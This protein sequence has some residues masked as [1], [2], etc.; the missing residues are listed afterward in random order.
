MTDAAELVRARV[1]DSVQ[2]KS[3]LLEGD[4]PERL[5]EAAQ[6]VTDALTAGGKVLFFGNGGSAADAMH[7]A[8]ELVG[9]FA[10]DR[11][12]LPALALADSASAVT[13]IGNDYG[14]DEVFARQVLA[15]G[16]AGDVAIGFSTSGS[17][18]NVVRGLETARAAGLATIAFCDVTA[19]PVGEAGDVVIAVGATSTPRVQEC[20][21]LLG[22]TL[23]EIV[24]QALCGEES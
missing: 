20:H 19:C 18:R 8:A 24:E 23:C 16:R 13:A 21:L 7:L 15:L 6:A 11:R 14:F 2:A 3:R 10:F 1:R 5:A 4:V 9:R 22:H 17:S 12:P